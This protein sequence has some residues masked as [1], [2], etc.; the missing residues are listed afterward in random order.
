MKTTQTTINRSLW[1]TTLLMSTLLLGC[2]NDD[3]PTSLPPVVTTPTVTSVTPMDTSTAVQIGTS[4]S[5]TFSEAMDTSTIN[6]ESFVLSAETQAVAGSVIVDAASNT[7]TFTPTVA[8]SASTTYKVTVTSA[9]TSVAGQALADDFVW[10]FTTDIVADTTA[11]TITSNLP[12]NEA[13][14]VALNS[15]ISVN[16]SEALAVST[17]NTTSFTVSDGT[18]VI[19]RLSTLPRQQSVQ[20]IR[21]IRQRILFLTLRSAPT[22]VKHLIQAALTP[23]ASP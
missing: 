7:A 9:A 20:P 19:T 12:L 13:V 11:P 15:S 4:V 6:D 21:L 10:S 17:I 2:Q 22:S 5:A 16:A 23:P 1:L 8:L 3:D 18:T 14:D